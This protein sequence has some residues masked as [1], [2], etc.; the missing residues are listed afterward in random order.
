MSKSLAWCSSMNGELRTRR[1]ALVH[2]DPKAGPG[3][4][5]F[6]PVRGTTQQINYVSLLGTITQILSTLV[7]TIVVVTR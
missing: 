3:A 5:V 2:S 7:V 6:V 4:E 1:R